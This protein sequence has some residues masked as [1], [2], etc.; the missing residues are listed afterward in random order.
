MFHIALGI[1]VN[2]FLKHTYA[3]HQ[4]TRKQPKNES[5]KSLSNTWYLKITY[6]QYHHTDI[7]S[8][9]KVLAFWYE[10]AEKFYNF[11]NISTKICETKNGSR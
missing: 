6:L 9:T 4:T 11:M 7:V 10:S 3:I 8:K 2:S 5:S 1:I